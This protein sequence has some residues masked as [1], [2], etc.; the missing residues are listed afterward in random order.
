MRT[1]DAEVEDLI[2]NRLSHLARQLL[3]TPTPDR[4]AH[5]SRATSM[6][7]KEF[8]SHDVADVQDLQHSSAMRVDDHE[9]SDFDEFDTLDAKAT[10]AHTN[11]VPSGGHAAM[12]ETQDIENAQ[13]TRDDTD[14]ADGA[15]AAD[16]GDASRSARSASADDATDAADVA[17]DIESAQPEPGLPT[18]E[19]TQ[20]QMGAQVDGAEAPD[21]WTVQPEQAQTP[22]DTEDAA[23]PS[24]TQESTPSTDPD[25]QQQP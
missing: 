6:V 11:D 20:A 1:D 9:G 14:P 2:E 24:D 19:L 7:E 4:P 18:H 12:A 15:C 17:G 25:D 22:A 8:E 5:Q 23:E 13:V 21:T 3:G 16:D 10:D